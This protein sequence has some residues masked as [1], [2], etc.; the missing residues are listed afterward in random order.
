MEINKLV[1]IGT[2]PFS[3][4]IATIIQMEGEYEV[5]AFSTSRQFMDK[6]EMNGL[7]IVAQEDL[8][9]TFNMGEVGII[10]TIGYSKM[11]AIR[12][13]VQ[14]EL[15]N[16]GFHLQTFISKN[17]NVYTPDIGEGSIIMPGAF[18]GPDVSVGKACIIYSNVSLTHH[19]NIE[20]YCFIA[21]G[22]VLGGNVTIG[23]NSFI[24]LN[25]TIRNRVSLAPYTLVGAA[26]NLLNVS[27]S[28]GGVI[29]GNPAKIIEGRDSRNSIIK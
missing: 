25:S 29:F 3:A 21:S 24:G 26:S 14:N 23:H 6:T 4:V 17:A 9:H 16:E 8:R 2:T 22:C 15:L 18:V 28:M 5:L 1:I 20:D 27:N 13:R 12:E 19:I 10:N 11:N 7:P